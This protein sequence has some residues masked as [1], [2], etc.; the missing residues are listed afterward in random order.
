[1]AFGGRPDTFVCTMASDLAIVTSSLLPYFIARLALG[2]LQSTGSDV[3]VV[4]SFVEIKIS[5]EGS[6]SIS[7]KFCIIR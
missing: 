6:G 3:S 5:S 1:M 2:A 7:A 4:C